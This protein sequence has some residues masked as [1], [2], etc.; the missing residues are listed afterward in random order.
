MY[1]CPTTITTTT[2]KTPPILTLRLKSRAKQHHTATRIKYRFDWGG[3]EHKRAEIHEFARKIVESTK[4]LEE[5]CE[6]NGWQACGAIGCAIRD[7]HLAESLFSP[8]AAQVGRLHRQL[9]AL[10]EDLIQNQQMQCDVVMRE[11]SVFADPRRLPEWDVL[12]EKAR[13]KQNRGR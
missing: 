11:S 4:E 10:N 5:E 12:I 3:L 8:L 6:M 2:I 13:K 9:R 1:F 7:P